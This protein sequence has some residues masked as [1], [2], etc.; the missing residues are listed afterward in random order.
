MYLDLFLPDLT[1][2]YIF[3][4]SNTQ[5]KLLEYNAGKSLTDLQ[6]SPIYRAQA[7]SPEEPGKS[8]VE[9]THIINITRA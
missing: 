3:Y 8:V 6:C 5:N 7:I 4:V 9:C 2:T 1:L